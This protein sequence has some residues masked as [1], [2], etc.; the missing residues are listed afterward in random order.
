MPNVHDRGGWPTDE[1]IDQSEHA[2]MDWERQTHALVTVLR[3]KGKLGTDALR[4]GIEAIPPAEYEA[5][6]YYERWSASIEAL[7]VEESLLTAEE[8]GHRVSALE[9]RWSA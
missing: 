4:R 8:I 1:T 7:L 2:I 6:S 9:K 5:L 3:G